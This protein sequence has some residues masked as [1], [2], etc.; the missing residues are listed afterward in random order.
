MAPAPKP[1]K[2]MRKTL[3][4]PLAVAAIL[5]GGMLANRA[6]AITAVTALGIAAVDPALVQPARAI[7]G[8]NGCAPV[9]TKPPLRHFKQMPKHI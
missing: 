7:C 4:L 3:H 8:T 6:E 5:S 1:R 2:S 9:Q